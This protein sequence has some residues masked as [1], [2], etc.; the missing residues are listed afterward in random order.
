MAQNPKAILILG[1]IIALLES[2]SGQAPRFFADDPIKVMPTPLP[3]G[4]PAQQSINDALDFFSRSTRLPTPSGKP[5]G[6]VNT[7]GE[8]PDSEW[9]VN[10]HAVHRMTRDELQRGPAL[11]EG[12]VAPFTVTG[13]KTAGVKPGFRMKDSTGRSYFV[14]VDP[15]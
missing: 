5:A 1:L 7:L 12:P 4:K 6:A 14:K 10:R 15:Y 3:V 11:S 8:V 2:A 13:G 9:F